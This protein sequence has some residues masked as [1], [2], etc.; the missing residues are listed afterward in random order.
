MP[1]TVDVRTMRK[2]ALRHEEV[3]I[4]LGTGHCHVQEPPLFLY[5]S[6]SA[7]TKVRGNAS[8]DDVHYEHR[9]P[10]LTFSRVNSR[11]DQAIVIKHRQTRLVA[12]RVRWI[13]CQ[14]RQKP[15]PRGIPA[16]DI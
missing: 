7:S 10:F 16:C 3:E 12:G 8:I 4:I 15:F 5:F 9:L 6:R 1:I 11:K 13:E 2:E 14:L